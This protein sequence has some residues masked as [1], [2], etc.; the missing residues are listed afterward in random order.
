MNKN[1]RIIRKVEPAGITSYAMYLVSY[2]ERG[3]I[4]HIAGDPA[5]PSGE[6]I[7]GL[8]DDLEQI[9]QALDLPVLEMEEVLDSVEACDAAEY[10]TWIREQIRDS[11]N[12][13]F[14]PAPDSV[15]LEAVQ[16]TQQQKLELIAARFAEKRRNDPD[17]F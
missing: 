13:A 16:Q 5:S 11:S 10:G 4:N 9:R 1:Y 7:D 6:S 3:A 14:S 2:D 12:Q 8:K 17:G 15:S